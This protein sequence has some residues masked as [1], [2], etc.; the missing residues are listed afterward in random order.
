MPA[1]WESQSAI[2]MAFPDETTDW[3]Y[4]LDDARKQFVNLA[5]AIILNGGKVLMLARDPEDVK[6]SFMEMAVSDYKDLKNSLTII[7]ITIND[8][9]TRD[10][11]PISIIDRD[12]EGREM[13]RAV[14]FGFN[15]WGLKFASNYDNTVV[16]RLNKEG[17]I[18]DQSYEDKRGFILE[19]GS[20]ETDGEGTL[21]TTS[22]CLMN[23]N[24]NP[25]YT[26]KEIEEE[27][28][29]TLGIDRVLWLD[30]GHIDGDDTDSHID[31]LCRFAPGNKIIYTGNDKGSDLQQESLKKMEMQLKTFI[32]R[33]GKP[34]EMIKL[35][36]PDPIYDEEG[37]SLAAT[38]VNYLVMPEAVLMPLYGC[39]K[40]DTMAL[41]IMKEVYSERKIVGVDCRTLV[42]QG[43]SLHCSTMQI[44]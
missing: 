31:T 12:G 27:L 19:G 25:G 16:K 22:E 32:T 9:W 21:L 35:P 30:Y 36:L 23:E 29:H 2:L 17:I 4:I 40:A 43:G 24:R 33:D 18:A 15:A 6:R 3:A 11:G 7:P 39:E 5:E 44:Y 20:L 38:Y 26:K 1:E 10:Y 41:E 28:F 14:D 8:T 34:Y 13:V 37:K 42:R